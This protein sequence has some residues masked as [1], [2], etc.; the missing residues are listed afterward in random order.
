MFFDP[1]TSRRRAFLLAVVVFAASTLVSPV[2][3]A[4]D[5]GGRVGV[6]RA[7]QGGATV[8]QMGESEPV[9]VDLELLAGD[10]VTTSWNARVQIVLENDAQILVDGDTEL[11]FEVLPGGGEANRP[12]VV[13]VTLARGELL[14]ASEL[15]PALRIDTHN[16]TTYPGAG[17]FRVEGDDDSTLVIARSGDAEVKTRHGA[18]WIAAGEQAVVAGDAPAVVAS[19]VGANGL[20]R[21]AAALSEGRQGWAGLPWDSSWSGFWAYLTAEDSSYWYE[22]Y[23]SDCWGG[24][25]AAC[26]DGSVDSDVD[27]G[28]TRPSRGNAVSDE[29]VGQAPV[30]GAVPGD[31]EGSA[32]EEEDDRG[33][34]RWGRPGRDE[35]AT[36]E[37]GG[38]AAL[39]R[40]GS[41]V[42]GASRA[43][44][45]LP[46]WEGSE[47]E[48]TDEPEPAEEAED[49]EYAEE[50]EVGAEPGLTEELGW[51]ERARPAEDHADDHVEGGGD[52]PSAAGSEESTEATATHESSGD[53]SPATASEVV[54]DAP[55]AAEPE[56]S[57]ADSP[58]PAPAPDPPSDDSGSGSAPAWDGGG[59]AAPEAREA[60]EHRGEPNR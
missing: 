57:A 13:Q 10:R 12:L 1:T 23:E 15:D 2:A 35:G 22:D 21:W 44:E 58:A 20:E 8:D 60:P 56:S 25:A 30:R 18:L 38:R 48:E 42:E 26:G 41:D 53:D 17:W 32:G 46:G 7:L 36:G 6:F 47:S 52:E 50:A 51:V 27:A 9:V 28:R 31:D 43:A 49:A 55:A 40:R 34:W 24:G 29:D 54:V 4:D 59:T 11:L 45:E 37:A 5:P 19:A 39:P 3:F 33:G 14:I 16:A